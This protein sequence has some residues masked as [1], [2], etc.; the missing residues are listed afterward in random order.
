MCEPG[1][2]FI[3]NTSSVMA[4]FRFIACTWFILNQWRE[5]LVPGKRNIH[6][7]RWGKPNETN[8][9]KG[10]R[11]RAS[12]FVRNDNNYSIVVNGNRLFIN[13]YFQ[14]DGHRARGIFFFRNYGLNDDPGEKR[15]RGVRARATVK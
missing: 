6:R 3:Y 10:S 11:E 5:S 15:G 1:M 4:I 13:R 8:I 9:V 12:L 7:M 14:W 2:F